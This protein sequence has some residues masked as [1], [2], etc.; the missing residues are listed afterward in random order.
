AIQAGHRHPSAF[1]R[2]LRGSRSGH[3]G[4][5]NESDGQG[6][7]EIIRHAWSPYLPSSLPSSAKDPATIFRPSARVTAL[8]LAILEPSLAST[9]ETVTSVPTLRKSLVQ[10]IRRSA[11]GLA[12]SR[13]QLV[14]A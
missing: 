14:T 9:A 6:G 1:R 5:C 13:F 2:N 12:S 10:P 3:K 8:V 7:N 4:C 11:L